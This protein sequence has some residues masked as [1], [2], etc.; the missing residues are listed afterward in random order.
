MSSPNVDLQEMRGFPLGGP[1][2]RLRIDFSDLEVNLDEPGDDYDGRMSSSLGKYLPK[3]RYTYAD[4]WQGGSRRVEEPSVSQTSHTVISTIASYTVSVFLP[5]KVGVPPPHTHN[6]QFY[7]KLRKIM[8][9]VQ[10]L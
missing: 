1:D 6:S 9:K 8:L 10:N 2:K 5:V 4:D 7:L 3:G